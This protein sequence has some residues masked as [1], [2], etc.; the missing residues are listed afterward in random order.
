M[1]GVCAGFRGVSRDGTIHAVRK[2]AIAR[3]RK[4]ETRSRYVSWGTRGDPG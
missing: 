3:S 2:N 4:I 1:N